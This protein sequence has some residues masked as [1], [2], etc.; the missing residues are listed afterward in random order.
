MFCTVFLRPN[1]AEKLLTGTLN[2]NASCSVLF[3]YPWPP[4]RND[5]VSKGHD[6]YVRAHVLFNETLTLNQMISDVHS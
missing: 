1:M 4:L 6:V 2:A 3:C 5:V